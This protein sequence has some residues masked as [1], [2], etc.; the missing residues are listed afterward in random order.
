MP[1]PAARRRTKAVLPAPSSPYRRTREPATSRAAR[2]APIASVSASERD[3]MA[4]SV[5]LVVAVLAGHGTPGRAEVAQDV[6]RHQ[7]RRAD[8]RRGEIAGLAVQVDA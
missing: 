6:A 3:R 8:R 5:T 2:S 7:R 1:S 4:W